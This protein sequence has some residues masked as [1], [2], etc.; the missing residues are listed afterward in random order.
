M[1][2]TQKFMLNSGS[3]A[4][5]QI[6]VMLVGFILPRVML[7]SYGSE[8]NGLVS[9]IAQFISYFNLVE[10]GL[11]GASIY[12]LYIPLAN[13]DHK[14]INSILSA[15]KKFYTQSGYIFLSLTVG[16]AFIYPLYI[17]T[18]AISTLSIGLLVLI[19]GTNG[20]LE[21]FTLSKYRALL[22][23]DQRTYV[24]SFASIIQ[25]IVNAVII[26]TLALFR[27]DI[28]MVRFVALLSIF[29][30]SFILM[31]YCNKRYKY[32]DYNVEPNIKA[33]DKRWDALY[34][35]ILGMI[36][37]G[38]PTL[39]ITLVLKDLKLVSVYTIFNMVIAG[40]GGILGIFISGLSA[41]FGELIAKKELRLLQKVYAEF[42][43]A[44]YGLI[45]V[46]YSITFVTIM[47]FINIYTA[48]VSD[49]N[50]DLPIVGFL[51]VLNGLLY[52]MKTPQGMLVISA[53]MYKETKWRST[54][55]GMIAVIVGTILAPI[56][57]IAGIL[58]GSILSNL[59]RDI[60]LMFFIPRYITKTPVI[61]T[62]RRLV[63]IVLCV[64]IACVP[65]HFI[66]YIPLTFCQWVI[67]AM[68]VGIYALLEVV[69]VNFIFDK[70]TMMNTL[71]RVKGMVLKK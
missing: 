66:Q 41:S 7:I 18:D 64:S 60:D 48:N 6:V 46:V 9:S 26:I 12:A 8:I 49:A 5:M 39:I 51:F 19:L 17:Q 31:M 44:Y 61:V 35:Q 1:N 10:A 13:E 29:L 50:Y 38:A 24:I 22:T 71:A 40:I 52:N 67:Y 68:G 55:Q 2:R 21:F 37:I 47:P 58:V 16:L 69:L 28:V 56:Y 43:F 27:V 23:A 57:G 62:F 11:S 65:F 20:A 63:R 15:V 53:G 25:I 54:I 32:I 70:K 42:E 14:G 34:L 59:Y 45:T 33:L 4:F 30:R 3:T 36:H